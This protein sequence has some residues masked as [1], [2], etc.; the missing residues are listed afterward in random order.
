VGAAARAGPDKRLRLGLSVTSPRPSRRPPEL[1][2]VRRDWQGRASIPHAAN[3]AAG[4]GDAGSRARS[5]RTAWFTVEVMVGPGEVDQRIGHL[6]QA[7]DAGPDAGPKGLVQ[8]RR[9][10][11]HAGPNVQRLVRGV[12]PGPGPARD[13]GPARGWTSRECRWSTGRVCV[14]T[15]GF[16]RPRRGPGGLVQ[17]REPGPTRS[18]PRG[19]SLVQS[20]VQGVGPTGLVRRSGPRAGPGGRPWSRS[21]AHRLGPRSPSWSKAVDPGVG[22]AVVSLVR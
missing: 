8:D 19:P 10:D 2:Q 9:A 7:H 14:S 15:C 21:L 1:D 12:G 6:D 20:L 3:A 4:R 13:R 17:Q 16:T 5:V 11:P 22:P 18:G